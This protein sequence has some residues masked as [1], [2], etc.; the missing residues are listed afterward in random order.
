M[1]MATGAVPTKLP[2]PVPWGKK[3]RTLL[4]NISFGMFW[5]AF[6]FAY[7]GGVRNL[8]GYINVSFGLFVAACIVPLFT[9]K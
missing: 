4:M 9:K 7:L 2:D 3:H 5:I 6:P 1:N 8:S